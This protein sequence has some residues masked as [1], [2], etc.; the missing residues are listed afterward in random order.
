MIKYL[1]TIDNVD[2]PSSEEMKNSSSDLVTT[3]QAQVAEAIE[4]SS[5]DLDKTQSEIA[6][7]LSPDNPEFPSIFPDYKV[8]NTSKTTRKIFTPPFLDFS[9]SNLDPDQLRDFNSYISNIASLPLQDQIKALT[10]TSINLESAL[11]AST[12]TIPEPF[13]STAILSTNQ[14]L[15]NKCDEIFSNLQTV[16]KTKLQEV[17]DSKFEDLLS[18]LTSMR[19]DLVDQQLDKI[20]QLNKLSEAIELPKVESSLPQLAS[21][22]SPSLPSS[23]SKL[24]E[25]KTSTDIPAVLSEAKLEPL[26]D[27]QKLLNK[28]NLASLDKLRFSIEDI[29]LDR[30][31]PKLE[32]PTIPKVL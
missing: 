9:N 31:I 29:H 11:G 13:S 14:D 30:K 16:D 5:K 4:L 22:D 27:M 26:K 3:A 18:S 6:A 7:L 2:I 15:F 17:K 19:E 8:A 24:T 12:A 28:I 25:V 10:S 32:F 21:S 20:D 1:G 23:L